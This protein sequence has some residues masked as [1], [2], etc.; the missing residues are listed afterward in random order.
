MSSTDHCFGQLHQ[1]VHELSKGKAASTSASA[2][3]TNQDRV[4][5]E[6]L[7]TQPA[8]SREASPLYLASLLKVLKVDVP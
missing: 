8:N 2:S 3:H 1:Q 5:E 4:V 7:E 6:G